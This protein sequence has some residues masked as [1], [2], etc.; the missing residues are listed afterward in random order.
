LRVDLNELEVRDIDEEKKRKFKEAGPVELLSGSEESHQSFFPL[1]VDDYFM[2]VA[3]L[4]K[5]HS[6]EGDFTGAC[7]VSNDSLHVISLGYCKEGAKSHA[8]LKALLNAQDSRVD[9]TKCSLYT[10]KPPCFDCT[11]A[12]LNA[13]IR[14]VVYGNVGK[15]GLEE[16]VEDLVYKAKACFKKYKCYIRIREAEMQFLIDIPGNE[17]I[18]KELEY[19]GKA[20]QN[21]KKD[22]QDEPACEEE[23]DQRPSYRD[24]FMAMAFLSLTRS[25]DIKYQVGVCL[26]TPA[27]H[28][29]V[30]LGYNGMPDGRGF[31]DNKM[32]WGSVQSE[33][34]CHAEVNTM[35]AGYRREADLSAC[36]L[37]VTLSPCHDC[38]K[39]VAQSG[40]K[41]VVFAQYYHNGRDMFETLGRL[42]DMNITRY[43]YM[44]SGYD[45]IAKMKIDLKDLSIKL[46]E[47]STIPQTKWK[48]K[49]DGK[50]CPMCLTGGYQKPDK[51]KCPLCNKSVPEIPEQDTKGRRDVDFPLDDYFMS[52]AVLATCRS[53]LPK[54]KR[55][56]AC[57]VYQEPRRAISVGYSGY[58][59]GL[60]DGKK[61]KT[62]YV[63]CAEFNAIVSAYRYHAD[64]T[65]A[66]LYT[67][68]V[69]CSRCA[70]KIIQSGI[71][72]VVHG[73]EEKLMEQEAREV[74]YWGKIATLKYECQTKKPII[75]IDLRGL[76]VDQ[77]EDG[78]GGG[79][80]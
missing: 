10:T 37:Y 18:F 9:L 60:S 40:I 63:C 26:V 31:K 53:V 79:A 39:L 43:E 16:D 59:D 62:K 69:P 45:N 66:T 23:P 3:I 32:D 21:K 17:V 78:D 76:V 36:T 50:R 27:P 73:G 72:T 38:S 46:G 80:E 47:S 29:L 34:N 52:L 11:Q 61:K 77:R 49:E 13:G 30:A 44:E 58:I 75:E 70:T 2:T 24:F 12:I 14:V 51:D 74:F 1:A 7:I 22:K 20:E 6:S 15:E 68:G 4:S 5:S 55:V 28:R 19:K 67:T 41:N 57:L 48:P 42:P 54:N 8:E 71:K 35:I 25:K 56:G 64:L 33:Y 65:S